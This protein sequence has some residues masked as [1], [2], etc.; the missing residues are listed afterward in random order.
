MHRAYMNEPV[1][2]SG[3]MLVPFCFDSSSHTDF[4]NTTKKKKKKKKKRK[5]EFIERFR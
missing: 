3:E 4:L 5:M 1:S 2:P